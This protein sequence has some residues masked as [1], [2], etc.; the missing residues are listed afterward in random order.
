MEYQ[1]FVNVVQV[2]SQTLFVLFLVLVFFD[3]DILETK[4][5]PLLQKLMINGLKEDLIY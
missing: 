1:L 4:S 5:R 2:L 3:S